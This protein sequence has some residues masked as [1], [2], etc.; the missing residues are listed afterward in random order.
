MKDLELKQNLPLSTKIRYTE[1]RIKKWY[2][3]FNGDV[4]VSFSGGKDSTVLLDICRKLYPNIEAVFCDTGLEFPEIREFVKSIDNVT[5]IKPR[6]YS[7]KRKGEIFSFKKVLEEY[8]WPIVSK[9]QAKYIREVQNGTTECNRNKRLYGKNGSRSGMISKKWQYLIDAPFKI[10]EKC[11]DVMKKR[12]FH[13]YKRRTGKVPMVGTMAEDSTFRKQSYL[14]YGCSIF[15][16][17]K[18]QSRPLMFWKEKDIWKY[19]KDNNVKYSKIYEMGYERTGC[20]FCLF[21]H[22]LDLQR[23]KNRI[24]LL[25]KT[26]PK[27]YD[28]CMNKLDMKNVLKYYPSNK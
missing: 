2:E 18:E 15:K 1:S 19:L 4:Y 28:Y 22:H 3:S 11:C 16:E 24:E 5:W 26:H 14:R 9:E 6:H 17:G 10:S 12:P 27:L 25:K 7:G 13:Q 23:G 8:G 20:V 21:G